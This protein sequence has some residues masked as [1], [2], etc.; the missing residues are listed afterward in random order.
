MLNV[1]KEVTINIDGKEYPVCCDDWNK[2]KYSYFFSALTYLQIHEEDTLYKVGLYLDYIDNDIWSALDEKKNGKILLKKGC[3]SIKDFI[4][5]VLGL[6]DGTVPDY[7]VDYF[8]Y[9]E[10]WNDMQDG[11]GEF[12]NWSVYP[13]MTDWGFIA[14]IPRH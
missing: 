10:V 8:D 13:V 6:K 14:L 2:L 12:E 1:L 11:E 9:D 4:N 5:E 7:I 3:T